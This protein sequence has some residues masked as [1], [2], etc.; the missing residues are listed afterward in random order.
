MTSPMT[1]SSRPTDDEI[2][3]EKNA[4]LIMG[5]NNSSIVSK[6]SVERLYLPQPHFYRYFV[7]KPQRRAPT[8]NR[9]YWLRMR[10]IDW[11]IRHFLEKPSDQRKVIVNF[12]CG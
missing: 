6:R 5:T 8:I 4:G 10:A 7:K 2:A 12:G 9:G 11:V 1:A 3:M